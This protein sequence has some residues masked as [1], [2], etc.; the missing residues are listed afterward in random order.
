[1]GIFSSGSRGGPKIPT[2][3]ER[4]NSAALDQDKLDKV[5][6]KED[7]RYDAMTEEER[8]K[9]YV[10]PSLFTKIKKSLRGQ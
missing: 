4:M 10:N 3:E 8:D 5:L 2:P 9:Y 1:M 7:A 6:S